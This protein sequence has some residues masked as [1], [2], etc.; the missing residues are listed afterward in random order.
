MNIEP[1]ICGTVILYNPDKS[2]REN[3]K[4]YL[5]QVELLIVVDNSETIDSK[6]VDEIRSFENVDY[7]FFTENL[8]VATALNVAANRAIEKGFQYMLTMDQDSKVQPNMV[9]SLL[10]ISKGKTNVGIIAP[11]HM[12][13][14]GTH[15]KPVG[16]EQK[17]LL[18]MTSGNLLSLEAYKIIGKFCEDYF[19]DYVDIEYCF[20]MLQNNFNIWQANDVILEHNEATIS[21]RHFFNKKVHPHNHKP[22]RLYYKTRNLLYLRRKYKN[23]FP[24]LMKTEYNSYLWTI[25][26]MIIYE[27]EKF[28]KLKMVFLGVCGY[29]TNSV[30]KG[31]FKRTKSDSR[32][33]MLI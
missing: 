11:L 10:E 22:F 32:I 25:V 1:R 30:G 33:K 8:G 24:V 28:L 16:S 31:I 26:R 23:V 12:H 15:L 27:E 7:I 19:I 4:S 17:V 3:I 20:R 6:L 14:Y 5:N 21:E 13:K 2:V 29:L 9:S 18:T